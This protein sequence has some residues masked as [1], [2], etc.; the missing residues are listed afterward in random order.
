MSIT[1][2]TTQPNWPASRR[3]PDRRIHGGLAKNTKCVLALRDAERLA[4]DLIADELECSPFRRAR[5]FRQ[6][7]GQTVHHALAQLRIA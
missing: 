7:T 6:W 2:E 5:T 3:R 1:S 4:L